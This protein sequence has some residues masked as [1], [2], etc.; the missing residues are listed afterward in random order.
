MILSGFQGQVSHGRL[1]RKLIVSKMRISDFDIC[2]GWGIYGP[3]SRWVFSVD[4][5][6]EL[7][8][9]SR[10]VRSGLFRSVNARFTIL[11]LFIEFQLDSVSK[12]E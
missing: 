7:S 3:I 6:P 9:L 11:G 4:V 1:L 2:I 12:S 10:L 8:E 5:G